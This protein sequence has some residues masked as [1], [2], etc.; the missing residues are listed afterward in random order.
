MNY[1]QFI[2]SKSHIGQALGFEPL[3][4]PSC[5]FDF[6]AYMTDWQIRRGR[7]A[8]LS[9]CGLGKTLQQLVWAE[10]IARKTNKRTLLV[11]PLSVG[12]QT[13]A[14]GVKFGVECER[15]RDGKFSANSK[16]IVTNYEQL[17]KF[18]PNDFIAMGCDE[19]SII[20]NV[21]GETRKLITRFMLKLPYRQLYTATPSPNDFIELGTSSEALGELSNTDM[22]KRFFVLSEKVPH[23][24]QQI[25]DQNQNRGNHFAKLSFRVHQNLDKWVI[26]G[27]AKEHFW[28]W[29]CSW[30]RA[31]RKPSDLGFN[32]GDFVLPSLTERHHVIEP[33]RPADGMLFTIPAVGLA[34]EREERRRTLTERCELAAQL[35]SHDKPAV[36]WAGLNVEGDLLEKII[37]GARQ[38]KGGQSD[39]EQEEIIKAFTGGELKKLVTKGKITAWGQ[40]WQHCAHSVSFASHSYEQYYQIVRRFWRFGQRS[41]V[42]SDII[43]TTGEKH[44]TDNMERKRI[45]AAEMFD[46]LI[47]HMHE[48]LNIQRNG[49]ET[50]TIK[51]PTWN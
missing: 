20:K 34:A 39:E 28:K 11:T 51:Q 4:M 25:K 36:V 31:C 19:S 8:N 37:P 44:V 21:S 5:L 46:Q 43:S 23:R 35:V 45:Q 40:N 29:V 32:D 41:P 18:D 14:E 7:A 33:K 47:A 49:H 50:I 10:N 38:L 17:D 30:A 1:E 6:Q 13:L 24:M 3:W 9:D 26:K 22:L 42:V 2:D 12:H 48:T 15:S 16:I 27:H